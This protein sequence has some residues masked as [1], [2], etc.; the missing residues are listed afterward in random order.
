MRYRFCAHAVGALLGVALSSHPG[1]A[2]HGHVESGPTELRILVHGESLYVRTI[3][4]GP[5]IIVLH[6]GPAFDMSYLLPE[7]DLLRDGHRLIYY[8][9]R[10]RGQS[11]EHTRPDDVSVES[12]VAD[13]DAVRQHFNLE[14]PV[15]LGHS[16]GAVLALEYALAHPSRVSRLVLMNPA[17]A[18][19]AD[20]AV[21][22]EA[23]LAQAG[24]DAARENGIRDGVAYQRGDPAAV[25]ARY[26]IHFEHAFA[27]PWDYEMLMAR[28]DSAFQRQGKQGILKARAIENRLIQETWQRSDYDLMPKL[29][30]L[31]IPSLILIG[32]HDFM[33]SEIGE[34]I[35]DSLPR[36]KLVTLEGC[37]HFA[38]LE[39][40]PQVRRA[41]NGFFGKKTSASQR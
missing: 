21:M 28:M 37:G 24:P 20:R 30:T 2:Q 4:S 5:P 9:Q 32:D 27:H 38:Y 18:S 16:W 13:L 17:P 8:D 29:H 35:A 26:R 11:A 34:H 6:G 36:A 1:I 19:A 3:G 40:G 41:L 22:A 10:G 33:P 12:D 31:H 23:Y 15:L 25:I 7:M 14:S 39:C